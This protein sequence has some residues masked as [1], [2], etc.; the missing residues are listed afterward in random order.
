MV[1]TGGKVGSSAPEGRMAVTSLSPDRHDIV[2]LSPLSSVNLL[3]RTVYAEV[4]HLKEVTRAQGQ[5]VRAQNF[6]TGSA[7]YR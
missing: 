2:A 4:A 7:L 3:L 1:E 6:R 5:N